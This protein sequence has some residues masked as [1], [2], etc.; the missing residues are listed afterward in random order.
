[1]ITHAAR[2]GRRIAATLLLSLTLALTACG[3]PEATTSPSSPATTSVSATVKPASVKISKINAESSLV[4]SGINT[5]GSIATPSV[6]QPMQA[7]WFD[8]STVPGKPGGAV[9]LGHYDGDGKPGIFYRLKEL[10]VGDEV[11]VKLS[12][13][14]DLK[15]TVSKTQQVDK[16]RLPKEQI[17]G[18]TTEPELRLIT[19]GGAFDKAVHSYT[20]NTVV[21]AKLKA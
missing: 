18:E 11:D 14:K 12:D 15:F 3:G 21:F 13:G 7:S 2:G 19:C 10:K 8:Q 1:M 6:H 9:L 4:A 20:E 5:D 16:N 17:F